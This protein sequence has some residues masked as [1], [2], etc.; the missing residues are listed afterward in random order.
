MKVYG[1]DNYF[2]A[3]HHDE[4]WCGAIE[5]YHNNFYKEYFC[6]I[7]MDY[8]IKIKRLE[9]EQEPE[10]DYEFLCEGLQIKYM[11]KESGDKIPREILDS[12]NNIFGIFNYMSEADVLDIKHVVP[13]GK[14]LEITIKD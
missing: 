2:L 8:T 5:F 6:K 13:K 7:F 12:E 14:T 1:G 11:P 9:R 4:V 3:E 10:K